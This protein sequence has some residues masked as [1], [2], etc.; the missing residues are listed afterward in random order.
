MIFSIA[1]GLDKAKKI[2][3]G[4]FVD[5]NI[6]E[7]QHIEEWIRTNPEMLGEDLLIVSIE[8]DRFTTAY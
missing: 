7:R 4:S 3:P 6:W 5:L 1:N 8:F 2:N